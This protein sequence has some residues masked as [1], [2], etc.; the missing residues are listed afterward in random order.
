MIEDFFLT[1][2]FASRSKED[3]EANFSI[4]VKQ[5]E[6]D[7]YFRKTIYS[8]DE[9]KAILEK[10]ASDTNQ[11]IRK[12]NR[13]YEKN[14]SALYSTYSDVFLQIHIAIRECMKTGNSYEVI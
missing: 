1:I 4:I 7:K 9:L 5:T 11:F 10:I 14:T 12:F 13:I 2:T 3:N 6:K 8:F